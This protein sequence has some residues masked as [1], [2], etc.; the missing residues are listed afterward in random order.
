MTSKTVLWVIAFAAAIHVS[1]PA[2][3]AAMISQ[4]ATVFGEQAPWLYATGTL[5]DSY[6]YGTTN[7]M[8]APFI[9]DSTD[10]FSFL[11]GSVISV[12]YVS[13]TVKAGS[14]GAF[15]A[16]GADGDANKPKNADV[17]TSNGLYYPSK[18]I[19]SSQ[20]PVNLGALVGTFANGSGAIVG[21]PFKIGVDADLVVPAGATRLQMGINDNFFGDNSGSFNLTVSQVPE[22]AS[23]AL[24]LMAS[25]GLLM[26]RRHQL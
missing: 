17:D 19:S 22:P 9:V 11:A 6:I 2:A 12:E 26:R 16:R 21:T 5:N 1:I 23:C 4:S 3:N 15:P 18:Y 13:G 20:F 24:A 10:G 25:A 8:S 7:Q 14:G